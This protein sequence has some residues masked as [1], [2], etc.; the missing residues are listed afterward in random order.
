MSEVCNA[1]A[2]SQV[3]EVLGRPL[4]PFPAPFGSAPVMVRRWFDESA[5]ATIPD[6]DGTLQ[7]AR[8][9]ANAYTRK[10]KADN[11]RRAYRAGVRAWCA[12]CD[13][14]GLPCLPA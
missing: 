13:T 4:L 1:K 3:G 8:R 5:A 12:W 6:C 10:S 14:H 7:A 2:D 11:T 9:A